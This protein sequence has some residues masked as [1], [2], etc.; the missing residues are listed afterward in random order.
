MRR[1]GWFVRAPTTGERSRSACPTFI[2]SL[3]LG[4]CTRDLFSGSV[5]CNGR[6]VR[7][8]TVK[9]RTLFRGIYFNALYFV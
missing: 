3:I 7:T 1:A 2:R 8:A 5:G 4:I 9:I 6:P